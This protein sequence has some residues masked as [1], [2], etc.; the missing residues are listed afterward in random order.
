VLGFHPSAH[1]PSFPK[2]EKQRAQSCC[3]PHREEEQ[4]PDQKS[5]GRGTFTPVVTLSLNRQLS[6]EREREL[7]CENR[8][9][10]YT[11]NLPNYLLTSAS[12]NSHLQQRPVKKPAHP[13]QKRGPS[14]RGW[15]QPKKERGC[16]GHPAGP[17]A[18]RGPGSAGWLRH[19]PRPQRPHRWVPTA[20]SR[21]ARPCA[22]VLCCNGAAIGIQPIWC[23]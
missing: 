23:A 18:A 13:S 2:K 19:R 22:A 9:W 6:G 7:M 12:L 4:L 5:W 15:R 8:L 20:P 14:C 17:T 16:W 1:S 11:G 21:R 10:T 3:S